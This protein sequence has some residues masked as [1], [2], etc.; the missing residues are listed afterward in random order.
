[1]T[2]R[3]IPQS[4]CDS[5]LI[6]GANL[7]APF[8]KGGT[9]NGV[10]ESSILA[11]DTSSPQGL[12]ALKTKEGQILEASHFKPLEHNQ[13]ILQQVASLLNQAHLSLHD[14]DYFAASVGPGSFVGTRLAVATTQ[15]L[16]FGTTKP[17]VAISHLA[18]IALAAKLD[19]VVLDAKMQGCYHFSRGQERFERFTESPPSFTAIPLFTGHDLITLAEIQIAAGAIFSDPAAL[20]PTYLHDESNWKKLS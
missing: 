17:V 7:I 10:G 6:K 1:M 4:L 14:I 16:A 11:V 12:V 8:N 19:E 2:L 18:L 13:F 15:G 9:S 20:Q 5:S 3:K